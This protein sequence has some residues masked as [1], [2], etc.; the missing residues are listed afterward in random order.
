MKEVKKEGKKGKKEAKKI[1]LPTQGLISQN[2]RSCFEVK[3]LWEM[4]QLANFN[5][6]GTPRPTPAC[7]V[8]HV[9]PRSGPQHDVGMG[10]TPLGPGG[11]Q[12]GLDSTPPKAGWSL[13]SCQELWELKVTL[14]KFDFKRQD[15][16]FLQRTDFVNPGSSG[17]TER[18]AAERSEGREKLGREC[19]TASTF[20]FIYTMLFWRLNKLLSSLLLSLDLKP[21]WFSVL[22]TGH[23]CYHGL[24]ISI[25]DTRRHKYLVSL[26][27]S[28]ARNQLLKVSPLISCSVSIF[29]ELCGCLKFISH[30]ICISNLD[31]LGIIRSFSLAA[32][33]EEKECGFLFWR[34][35]LLCSVLV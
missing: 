2:P 28:V 24:F 22:E 21:P 9:Q 8:T 20:H 18:H 34:A 19:T 32:C 11:R 35:A 26:L 33:P 15:F 6:H 12:G 17:R 27:S 1:C 25:M 7:G 14:H 4:R 13:V 3:S 23:V 16:G 30:Y 31:F 10:W 29:G 5:S